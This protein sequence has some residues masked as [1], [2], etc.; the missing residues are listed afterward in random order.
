MEWSQHELL[1]LA[2]GLSQLSE[3]DSL[4]ILASAGAFIQ[5]NLLNVFKVHFHNSGVAKLEARLQEILREVRVVYLLEALFHC[6]ISKQEVIL[7]GGDP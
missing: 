6:V 3:Q 2:E 4:S 5:H 7:L 1:A